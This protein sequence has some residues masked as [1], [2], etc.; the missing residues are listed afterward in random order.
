MV[1]PASWIS[2]PTSLAAPAGVSIVLPVGLAG[3]EAS[4]ALA[5]EGLGAAAV[6][7]EASTSGAG[8]GLSHPAESSDR[9]RRPGSKGV[10][11]R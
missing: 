3:G 6:V 5:L 8:A 11:I 7:A 4:I 9:R 1:L 10:R 2:L